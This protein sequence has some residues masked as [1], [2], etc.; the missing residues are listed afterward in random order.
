LAEDLKLFENINGDNLSK[1][2]QGFKDLASGLLGFAKVTE[3]DL[4]KASR[5]A[6][7]GA[8]LAKNVPVTTTTTAPSAPSAPS[9]TSTSPTADMSAY[10]SRAGVGR[11]GSSSPSSSPMSPTKDSQS[12]DEPSEELIS[13]IKRLEGFEAKAKWDYKQY[14]NGYGTKA[15]SEN[16]VIDEKEADRR[17]RAVVKETRDKVVAYG[18]KHNYSFNSSQIDSL[19]SFAYNLGP[20]ILDKVTG[21]GKRTIQEIAEAI[22]K[23][24][25]VTKNGELVVEPGLDKRRNIELAMFNANPSSGATTTLASASPPSGGKTLASESTSMSDQR[26]GGKTASMQ[27]STSSS[28]TVL[29]SASTTMSDQR[30]AAMAPSG[31][32]TVIN[33]KPVNVASNAP[34]SGGKTA[35]TYDNELFQTLVGFQ[36]MSA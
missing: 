7:A 13:N 26:M 27:P 3:E 29:A 36:S 9:T 2:G 20:G 35:S 6:A 28:G 15:L 23:Y 12:G 31:G 10:K 18:K 19:T 1:V 21:G 11:E 25:K 34:S 16:E 30:M 33:N 14:S 17:L 24:N 4:V 22:P 32:N 5:A 8:A